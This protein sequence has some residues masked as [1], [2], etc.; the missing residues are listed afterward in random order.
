MEHG[1]WSGKGTFAHGHNENSMA[2][3]TLPIEI[4]IYSTMNRETVAKTGDRIEC[5]LER[6]TSNESYE[7]F[8]NE[9]VIRLQCL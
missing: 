6:I 3:P 4:Y 8:A 5:P 9:N 7:W 1:T 2:L